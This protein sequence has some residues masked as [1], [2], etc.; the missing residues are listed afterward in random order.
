MRGIGK[1]LGITISVYAGIRW[2]FPLVIPF[3]AAFLLAKLLNPLVEKLENKLKLKRSIWS[4]LL[5][6]A[7]L[8]LLGAAIFFFLK[9]LAIQVKNVMENLDLYRQ[10]VLGRMLLPD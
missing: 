6:G 7:L 4:S 9:T 10:Q 3:F 1:I 8:L 2:L 5:V